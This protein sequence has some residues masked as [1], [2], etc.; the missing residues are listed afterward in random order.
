[1]TWPWSKSGLMP[2]VHK[3]G[4]WFT[5]IPYDS[6]IFTCI[7]ETVFEFCWLSLP[8]PG[9]NCRLTP[10]T[11]SG[12]L[13]LIWKSTWCQEAT[14]KTGSD[15]IFLVVDFLENRL[16]MYKLSCK[17]GVRHCL[18]MFILQRATRRFCHPKLLNSV[19]LF[20][21][22]QEHLRETHEAAKAWSVLFRVAECFIVR[23]CEVLFFCRKWFCIRLQT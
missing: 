7:S 19:F 4:L 17:D 3:V 2:S 14:D 5:M 6:W 9:N 18:K 20:R 11:F 13:G 10:T 8:F 12:S 21:L 1:M 23:F 15:E 16:S 22:V